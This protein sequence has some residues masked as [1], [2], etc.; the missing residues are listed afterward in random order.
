M[1]HKINPTSFRLK[2]TDTWKSKWFSKSSYV[3]QLKEDVAIR[4][5][6]EKHLRKA[7]L[8]R[9]D[10]ERLNDGTITIVIRTTKP[11]LIIGKGGAGIEELKKLPENSLDLI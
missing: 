4:E 6:L 3:S 2:I 10:I 1:G 8:A 5:Y 11:G 7:G 9:I